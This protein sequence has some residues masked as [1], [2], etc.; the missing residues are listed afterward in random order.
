[1]RMLDKIIKYDVSSLMSDQ[2]IVH[3]LISGVTTQKSQGV[4]IAGE[5]WECKQAQKCMFTHSKTQ[6]VKI[7]PFTP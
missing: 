3:P 7:H 1:M 2:E 4:K 6:G 5:G